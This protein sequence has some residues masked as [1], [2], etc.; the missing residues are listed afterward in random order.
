MIRFHRIGI[1]IESKCMKIISILWNRNRI[2]MKI[3]K[4]NRNRNRIEMKILKR[5]RNRNRIEMKILKRN[6]NRN[7]IEIK[8]P[9]RNR[10]RKN[11]IPIP[12]CFKLLFENGIGI[13]IR[14]EL[15]ILKGI[16]IGIESK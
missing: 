4:R 8:I 2:E 13:E 5:N 14:I 9:K 10:N 11:M 15:K 7:R 1:G 12:L 6:R 3:L 16:R